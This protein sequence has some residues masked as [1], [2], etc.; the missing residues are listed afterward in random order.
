M[1]LIWRAFSGAAAIVSASF[2]ETANFLTDWEPVID[3]ATTTSGLALLA[4]DLKQPGPR[5]DGS[6]GYVDG[7]GMTMQ[8]SFM[9]EPGCFPAI[10][11]V[12]GVTTFLMPDTVLVFW[13]EPLPA[14]SV[15]I[16]ADGFVGRVAY[17]YEPQL[18]NAP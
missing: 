1:G 10:V 16:S 8:R 13:P 2:G 11:V 17:H 3:G 4:P 7:A 12:I 18:V 9:V 6:A 15:T 14:S 5:Y